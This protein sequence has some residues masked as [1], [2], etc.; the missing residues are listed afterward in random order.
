MQIQRRAMTQSWWQFCVSLMFPL[1]L[2][3][4]ASV[5]ISVFWK[6]SW[7]V[8]YFKIFIFICPSTDSFS[9]ECSPQHD[10]L[11]TTFYTVADSSKVTPTAT[12]EKPA[13]R[14]V[15]VGDPETG[16]KFTHN[17]ISTA[18]Y[19]WWNFLPKNL[20]LQFRLVSNIY[21]LIMVILSKYFARMYPWLPVLFQQMCKLSTQTQSIVY[22][23]VIGETKVVF[24]S[25]QPSYSTIL[26]LLLVLG[27]NSKSTRSCMLNKQQR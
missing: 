18:K 13:L 8:S 10:L 24:I 12:I 19:T 21:F 25:T 11:Q 26:P 4:H 6:E 1:Q 23:V 5:D 7:R 17:G 14:T 9:I 15:I 22:A 16:A 3:Q 20:F 27:T 2:W